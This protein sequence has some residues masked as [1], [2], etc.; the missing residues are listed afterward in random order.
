MKT[1]IEKAK[2]IDKIIGKQNFNPKK[3]Y[4][5]LNFCIFEEKNLLLYNNLTK[6][7]LALSKLENNLLKNINE[8]LNH[9]LIQHLISGWFIVPNDFDDVKFCE[10]IRN[11]A[12]VINSDTKLNSYDIFTTTA[13]NARCF[14]CFEAN[15]RP[16]SMTTETADAVADYIIKNSHSG[17]NYIRWF[18]GE[19]LCNTKVIDI[20]CKKLIGNNIE[21]VSHMTTNGYLFDEKLL[22]NVDKWKLKRVQIT[23]DGMTE[24]YNRVKNYVYNDPNPFERVIKNI[25]LL[26][27]KNIMVVV[28]LNMDLYNEKELYDVVN[29]LYKLYG[30]NKK[31]YIYAKALFENVGFV[32]T[33]HDD[34][35]KTLLNQKFLNLQ[36]Y[37]SNIGC[38][39]K[40]MLNNDIKTNQCMADS[41]R[42]V[43]ISPEGNLGRCEHHPD[44]DFYGSVFNNE[45][46]KPWDEY[47]P[48]LDKCSKCPAYPSCIRLKNC[49]TRNSECDEFKQQLRINNI[50]NAMLYTY[51][52]KK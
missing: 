38:D 26:L 33:Q 46:R 32:K 20:I 12:K 19:P 27:N 18:G 28:R 5:L 16:I 41:K 1:I 52:K 49:P 9:K 22:N 35:E 40:Y 7:L 23:L 17:K 45:P 10:Q 44:D 4:R 48:Y 24:T 50:I 30:Q 15:T 6:E 29:Y 31:F 51:F 14:Y 39:L 3:E 47:H 42:A 34:L 8:N 36:N 43:M 37:I 25:G 21:F 11:L 13:C 2:I